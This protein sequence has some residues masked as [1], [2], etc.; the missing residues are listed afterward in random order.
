[1]YKPATI[2]DI[3]LALQLSPSTV[4]RALRDE[5]EI[6]AATK[7]IVVEYARSVNYKSNPNALSLKNKRSY[8]IGIVVPELANS[9]FSQAI[10]GI[11]SVAY[12]KGY[13]TIITQT[14]D[15]SERELIN[16]NHLANR[17][18]D[19]LLISMSSGT[20]DYAFLQKLHQEGLPIV[21]FDRIIA[22]IDTF[23]ITSDNFNASYEATLSLIAAGCKKIAVLA[24]APQLSITNERFAGYKKALL[25]ND[26]P[27]RPDLVKNCIKGGS[28]NQEV[29]EAVRE[30]LSGPD[31]PDAIFITSDRISISCI[32][33]LKK[34]N[35]D[36]QD[37]MV[38]GFS[39]SD[40][41]DLLQPGLSY[42]RQKAFEMGEIA[43]TMLLK[44]IESKYP[45]TEFETR[46][47]STEFH[48]LTPLR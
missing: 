46:I 22:E 5:Y 16:V 40:V 34:L 17:S 8:S 44:L 47:L 27:L 19:G 3:A 26:I 38:L 13:H 2:K 25:E 23:K 42:I 36:P 28:D 14:H 35:F 18:V 10:A 24:N 6:S 39:N 37:I 32:R 33:A 30:L 45:V 1:M 48:T 11:E 20:A 43:V 29:E 9:F 7:K 12:E 21:F 15:S 4:S 41:V 31:K